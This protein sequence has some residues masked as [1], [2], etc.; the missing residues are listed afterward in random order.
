MEE[1]DQ[2]QKPAKPPRRAFFTSAII[3]LTSVVSGAIEGCA[4]ERS[5]RKAEDDAEL[6]SLRSVDA[7]YLTYTESSPL[8][9]G[10]AAPRGI[11]VDQHGSV[12]VVGDRAVRRF[13]KDGR[14]LDDIAIGGDPTCIAVAADG[15]I[16]VGVTDHVEVFGL[17][18]HARSRWSAVSGA[19]Y[20]TA[21][22]TGMPGILVADAGGRMVYRC[23]PD[24]RI[25][26]RIGAKEEGKG[27]PGLVIPSLHLDVAFGPNGTVFV[28]NPGMHRMETHRVD[29]GYLSSWGTPA[30][31]LD[32]FCGCCNPTD[33]ACLPHGK[34]ATAEK[35][36]PRVKVYSADGRF[37][38]VVAAPDSFASHA[39]GLDL[40]A[41]SDG[42]V[43]VLDPQRKTVRFFTRTGERSG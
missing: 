38:E 3:G 17:D 15:T 4:P 29:G 23:D 6:G 9:T 22:A 21:V 5:A 12:L 1:E 35:G 34:F 41:T 28:S 26:A 7:R 10:M 42:R 11:A 8:E 25:A 13:G 43:L 19:S 14:Q 31:T 32:A 37:L 40:A 20:I 24:G 16:Y 2:V 30:N 33:F 39:M 27:Y 18:G 36:I